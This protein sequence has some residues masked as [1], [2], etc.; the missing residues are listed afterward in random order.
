MQQFFCGELLSLCGE[1][2]RPY[3][4]CYINKV[5]HPLQKA[6]HTFVAHKLITI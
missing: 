5:K 6:L 4:I 2:H 1:K 3:G